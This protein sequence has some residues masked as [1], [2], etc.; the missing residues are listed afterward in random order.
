MVTA[1]DRCELI[2]PELTGGGAHGGYKYHGGLLGPDN[3]VYGFPMNAKTV[4]RVKLPHGLLACELPLPEDEPFNGGKY[5]WGGGCV[6][7]GCV[8]GVPSDSCR[9]LKIAAGGARWNYLALAGRKK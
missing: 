1:E 9:V 4:L 2:G 5:K 6:A 8:Y 7:N 3:C